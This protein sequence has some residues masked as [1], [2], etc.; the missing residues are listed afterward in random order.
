VNKITNFNTIENRNLLRDYLYKELTQNKGLDSSTAKARVKALMT[1]HDKNLFGENSLAYSLGKRSLSFFCQYFLQ[2][3]FIPKDNNVVR[4]LAPV[5]YEVWK[6]LEDIFIN[7]KH[8]K[9]EFILP[10]GCAK[11]TI[12]DMALSCY[13]HCYG[14]SRY[15]IVLANRE[16]DAVN[17][18][19]QTKQALKTPHIVHAFGNLVNPRK[20]TVNKL[21]LELDNDTKIQAYSSGSSV[22]GAGYISPKGIYRPMV[23]IADDYI[24]E[25]DI[26][27]DDSKQKKYQKWLKEVEEGGDAAVYRNGK[28][29]KPATK[30]LVLGTPLAQG[31]FIDSISKNPEYKVFHRSVVEFNV[32]EYFD[33]HEYWQEFRNILFDDKREDSTEDA[34]Q[35]FIENQDCMEFLTIWEKY[36][37]YNLALKYFT[38][39]LA[40]MQELMCNVENIGDKWFK[41]NR[42]QTIEEIEDHSFKKTLLTIDTAGVKN[43]NKTRSDYFAFVVGSLADNDFKYIRKGQLRKFDEFDHYINHVIELLEEFED[44]THVFIEKNTYNG[45][46]VERIENEIIKHPSIAKRNITFINEMQ[47]KNKDEKISTIVSDVD[48]GRIIFCEERVEKTFLDQVMDFSGQQFTLHDDAADCLAE[49]ANRIDEIKINNKRIQSLDR[50][51]LGL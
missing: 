28:L 42:T 9:Q 31:D 10:R 51:I 33:N 19:D 23:Y 49:F 20:R 17:F 35:Y 18:V 12:I 2:D 11:T 38:K 39:R 41:S 25:S 15:T 1:K 3:F 45:L 7:H 34:K 40:F 5:H 37:C 30:F 36:D 50:K 43:K 27:T 46:D 48:N 44:L 26:L 4:P 14:L 29:I 21:E 16:L 13:L 32:D 22:R 24:A 47:R 6:Q 8:D